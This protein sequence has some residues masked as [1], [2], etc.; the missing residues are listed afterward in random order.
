MWVTVYIWYIYINGYKVITYDAW[1]RG[2]QRRCASQEV[3]LRFAV[4]LKRR[5]SIESGLERE[6]DGNII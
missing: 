1:I 6:N 4:I 3:H 5:S 2:A